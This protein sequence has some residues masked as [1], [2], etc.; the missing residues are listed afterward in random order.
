MIRAA[1]IGCGKIAD[2]HATQIQRVPKCA[3]VAVCD[4]E[5]L[6]AQQ[7]GDRF[8]I[9]GVYSDVSRML[10]EARPDVVHVTTPPDAHFAIGRQCLEAGAH[11]YVEKP[12][13]LCSE[14]AEALVELA[15]KKSL[16]LTVGHNVQF[17]PESRRM[18]ALVSQGFLGGPPVH[19][20]SLYCYDLGEGYAR[21]F[22]GDAKHWLRRLPGKLL[23]NLISH[24]ISKIA[25]FLPVDRPKV[26]ANAFVSPTLR[27]RGESEIMDEL[28]V[29]INADNITTAYFTFSSRI[30][31]SQNQFRLY[32]PRNSLIVDQVHQ[33]LV[34]VEND[35]YKAQLK[36]FLPPLH[37]ARQYRRNALDNIGKF[38]RSDL[39]MD[40]GMKYLIEAFYKCIVESVAP[41]IPYREMLLVA[42]IM[43]DIFA[44]IGSRT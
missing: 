43:D 29:M 8:H 19:M 6:M 18:R 10:A 28:R 23:Q 40:A 39:H 42:R 13:T 37:F 38:L 5:L 1:I 25:E 3:I 35:S 33:T 32:G 15:E 2:Q 31:P 4:R 36:Y 7:L 27:A 44:Q 9:G 22:L 41:P 30:G 24:G 12:F 34:S 17:S 26:V 21:A 11:V 16:K 20:E 14:D